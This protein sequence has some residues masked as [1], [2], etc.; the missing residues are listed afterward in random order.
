[1]GRVVEFELVCLTA[2]EC[3]EE[4][5]VTIDLAVVLSGGD[6]DVVAGVVP[7]GGCKKPFGAEGFEWYILLVCVVSRATTRVGDGGVGG[8]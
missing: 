3:V 1:M 7:G 8:S 5:S 6:P 2:V 4:G